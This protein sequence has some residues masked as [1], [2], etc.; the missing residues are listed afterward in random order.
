MCKDRAQLTFTDEAG[1]GPSGKVIQGQERVKPKP[2]S[3]PVA[4]QSHLF[5][6]EL[7]I[8]PGTES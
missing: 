4:S 2:E 5:V 6:N 3:K 8:G 7:G 1:V